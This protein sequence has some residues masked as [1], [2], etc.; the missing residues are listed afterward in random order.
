MTL[1]PNTKIDPLL[2]EY[3]FLLDFLITLSPRFGLLRN[4]LARKTVAKAATVAQAATIGGLK[5]E[6][7]V[8]ALASEIEKQ[9]GKKPAV[10][11]EKSDDE[12]LADPAARHEVLKDI[13]RQL[14][15]GRDLADAKRRFRELIRQVDPSEISAM[16]QKL[17]EEGMPQEEVKRL[18]DVHVQVFRESL[19]RAEAPNVPE[20]HPVH[21]FML[22]NRASENLMDK[23]EKVLDTLGEQPNKGDLE[24]YFPSLQKLTAALRKIDLH[25]LRKENQL[26]PLLEQHEVSG[27]SQVMWGLHDDIRSTLK[28]GISSLE[29]RESQKAPAALREA[30]QAI[31]D[32]IYKEEH[33]LYPLA[34]ETLSDT[35]WARV[36][37]GEEEIGYA[38]IEPQTRWMPAEGSADHRLSEKEEKHMQLDTGDL[39]AEQINLMLK[40]LPIDV[41]FVDENDTVRYY[42]AT[43]DRVFPRSPGVIGRKVQNCHP[44]KSLG[45]VQRILDDFRNGE[46][47][48]AEFWIQMKGRFIHIRYYALHAEDGAYRGCLEASQDVTGIRELTGEKRLL[49]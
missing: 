13:I 22:E 47:D 30:I 16:E 40:A 15:E 1:S 46:R 25:Y 31:R 45:A 38:W 48:T 28:K 33:I 11:S 20:G 12:A 8:D 27:P 42:S 29:A 18:C 32:M 5:P 17:I 37:E 14:H 44:P 35:D 4:P 9:T 21:T 49:D 6:E 34:L 39:S 36:K 43:P 10:A 7:L 26:F 3:P 19:E 41:S 2:Q 24:R 23:I